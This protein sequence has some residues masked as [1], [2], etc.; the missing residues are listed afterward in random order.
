MSY[1]NVYPSNKS[2]IEGNVLLHLNEE[3]Y[4]DSILNLNFV[5]SQELTGKHSTHD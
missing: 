1:R 4:Q 2:E 3:V 5:D